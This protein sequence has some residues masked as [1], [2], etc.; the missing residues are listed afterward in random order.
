MI[1]YFY[2]RC[3]V[4]EKLIAKFQGTWAHQDSMYETVIYANMKTFRELIHKQNNH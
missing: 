2:F 1:D 4:D 3:P